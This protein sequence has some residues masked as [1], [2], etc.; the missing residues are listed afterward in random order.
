TRLYPHPLQKNTHHQ[1]QTTKELV[2]AF[3]H[4]PVTMPKKEEKKSLRN[5]GIGLG[6]RQGWWSQGRGWIGLVVMK[7]SLSRKLSR[8]RVGGT[9]GEASKRKRDNAGDPTNGKQGSKKKRPER[10]RRQRSSQP[11][12]HWK[13]Q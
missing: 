1:N 11:N 8:L 10:V 12:R 7:K 5:Q 3:L 9:D 4:L 13:P 2:T 6:I